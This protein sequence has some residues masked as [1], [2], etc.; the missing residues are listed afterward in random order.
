[1][2]AWISA[3]LTSTSTSNI[4]SLQ[5]VPSLANTN[6][7]WQYAGP[8]F[9]LPGALTAG[10]SSAAFVTYEGGER[11]HIRVH[12]GVVVGTKGNVTINGYLIDATN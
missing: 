8:W 1:M 2:I 3:A 4:L 7:K 12:S 6:L 11:P 5:S 9:L 10:M